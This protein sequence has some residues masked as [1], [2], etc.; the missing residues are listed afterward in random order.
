MIQWLTIRNNREPAE[1]GA[2]APARELRREV[3]SL[4]VTGGQVSL[5]AQIAANPLITASELAKRERISAPGMS[6]HLDGW[7]RRA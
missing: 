4:G 7:N 1:A 2:A 6:G 5:L 3:H